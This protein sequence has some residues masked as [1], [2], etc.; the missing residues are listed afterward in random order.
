MRG[1]I[2]DHLQQPLPFATAM[3]DSTTIGANANESGL[4]E[5]AYPPDT[6][7]EFYNIIISYDG[8][9]SSFVVTNLHKE[10]LFE[11]S[12]EITL[13]EVEIF[14][15]GSGAYIS[16]LQPIKTEIINSDE[17]RKAACCDL[18]GCFETQSTVQP[19]TTNIITNAKEL[20]ILG[21]SGVYNQVLTDGIP[22]TR[23]LT[24]TYGISTLPG[25]IIDNIWVVKGA[26]SVLQGFESMVGQIT[27]YP[28]EGSLA[29]PFSADLLVN[30][31]SE[32]HLNASTSIKEKKWNNY[33]AFHS[34]QPGN[35]Y[36]RD[37]DGFL[38]LPLITRYSLYNKWRYRKEDENG[39]SAFMGVHLVDEERIGGQINF[40]PLTD[41]G[42]TKHY[43]Q[44]ITFKQS[45]L[46]A[47]VGYRWDANRKLSL[48]TS[49]AFHEQDSWFG[50]LKYGGIQ[51]LSYSNL[52]YEL[53]WGKQKRN[54]LKAGISHRVLSNQEQISFSSDTLIRSFDGKY[55]LSEFIPGAFAE[56]IL[57]NAKS[58]LTCITGIRSDYHNI[59][60]WKIT[61]RTMLR[62][63]PAPKTDI[64]VSAGTGWRTVNLFAENINLL[65]SNREII[66]VETIKPEESFNTGINLTQNFEVGTMKFTFSTDFYHTRFLHQFFPDYDFRPDTAI[67]TNF[68]GPSASN[69]FQADLLLSNKQMSYRLAYNFVEAFR[70]V[71]EEKKLLPFNSKHRILGVVSV[72]SLEPKWQIDLNLHWYGKQRLPDI[73]LPEEN[74]PQQ[75]SS[76]AFTIV[77]VQYT[78]SF[79]GIEVFA[80]CENI[81][82]FRQLKP[83]RGWENPFGPSFDTSYAWGP[84]RGREIYAGVRFRLKNKPETRPEVN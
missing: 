23:G 16:K 24:Y 18:A 64:R 53:F 13:G 4:F 46:F 33:L 61:P 74:Q 55:T 17:L 83:I 29:D 51:H 81:A 80:G 35:K 84:T 26:N 2:V 12:I 75:L 56:V 49:Y 62:Y 54:D 27:I 39:I 9:S 76:D 77:S 50:I 43:G 67:I 1:E 41:L 25:S 32:K 60:G 47:K 79:K 63:Q 22:L 58:T 48:T 10:W 30:S 52:Q 70:K 42:T 72:H 37:E 5:I 73:H 36:D 71:E 31:F 65:A 34:S 44:L 82:D 38:D 68:N 20:R 78:R 21:L 40:D 66:F 14:D 69:G 6:T 45:A 57:K 59:F 3:W 19:Q 8:L 28:K 15:V 7:R 11:M